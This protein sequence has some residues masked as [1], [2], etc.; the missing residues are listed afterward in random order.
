MEGIDY[1]VNSK[2]DYISERRYSLLYKLLVADFGKMLPKIFTES[3]T[4]NLDRRE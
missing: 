3:T 4:S 2:K 1:P